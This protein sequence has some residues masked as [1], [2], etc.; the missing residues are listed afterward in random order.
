VIEAVLFDW[1]G[2][3]SVPTP[4]DLLDMWR[5]AAQ[6]LAPNDPEPVAQRLLDAE[7][8]WWDVH[9]AAGDRS[10]TTQELICSVGAETGL[11]VVAAAQE[12]YLS[13]WGATVAHD[14][15]A[16]STLRALKGRGLRTGLLSNTH[17]PRD[18]HEAWLEKDGLLDLLD[19]R[20][21]TSDMTHMKPHR[22]AF[23]ALLDA[24]GV[25]DPRRAVFVGDRPRDDVAGA[26]AAGMRA[27]LLTGRPVPPGDVEPDAVL[28]D[29]SGLPALLASW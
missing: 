2:T 5:R 25:T 11:D 10:G 22:E 7:L 16:V 28:P 21:Y 12:A 3:L 1:G 20:L 8:H 18:I 15:S 4:V 19:V 9:V 24:V 13:A 29:L 6:V 26:K 17:W 14:P 27:V 23:R